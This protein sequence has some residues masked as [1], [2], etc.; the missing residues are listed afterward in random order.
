MK[1]NKTYNPHRNESPTESSQLYQNCQYISQQINENTKQVLDDVHASFDRCDD[2]SQR[3]RENLEK[4][5][6]VLPLFIKP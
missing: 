2:L 4:C 5:T 1:P 3:I 6:E